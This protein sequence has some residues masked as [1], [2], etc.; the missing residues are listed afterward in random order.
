MFVF[1]PGRKLH[2]DPFRSLAVCHFAVPTHHRRRHRRDVRRVGHQVR[3]ADQL[4]R[5]RHRQN[6]NLPGHLPGRLHLRRYALRHCRL[7]LRQ[8]L[9]HL[10]QRRQDDDVDDNV[11]W[12][13]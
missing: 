12:G 10:R 5:L 8:R 13:R 2:V 9:E 7:V 4:P 1:L 11:E 3:P 6:E